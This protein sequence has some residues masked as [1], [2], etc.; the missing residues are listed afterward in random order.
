MYS[1][2]VY[3]YMRSL[4]KRACMRC[5]YRTNE[6]GGDCAAGPNNNPFGGC[7]RGISFVVYWKENYIFLG[8]YVGWLYEQLCIYYY[9]AYSIW[10]INVY[11]HSRTRMSAIYEDNPCKSH[12]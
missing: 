10:Y 3:E 8:W 1:T 4:W 11:E 2:Y 9:I 5:V 12:I 7:A 6:H